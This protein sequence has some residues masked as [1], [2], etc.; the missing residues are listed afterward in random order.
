M[1]KKNDEKVNTYHSPPPRES[2]RLPLASRLVF[3]PAAAEAKLDGRWVG[4]IEVFGVS[5]R[6]A[7]GMLRCDGVRTQDK[8]E[9]FLGGGGLGVGKPEN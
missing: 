8:R 2:P 3:W 6:L 1:N 4:I 7:M 5:L 9:G